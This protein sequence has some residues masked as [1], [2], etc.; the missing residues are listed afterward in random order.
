MLYFVSK[1]FKRDSCIHETNSQNQSLNFK[2]NQGGGT[3]FFRRKS[4]FLDIHGGDKR[5]V[6]VDFKSLVE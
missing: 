3:W 4:G 1:F 6:L 2:R 5:E